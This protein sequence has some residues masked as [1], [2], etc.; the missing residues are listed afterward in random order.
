VKEGDRFIVERSET[1]TCP[2]V[3][4]GKD[5]KKLKIEFVSS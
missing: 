5:E 4:R 3:A 1:K 2:Q